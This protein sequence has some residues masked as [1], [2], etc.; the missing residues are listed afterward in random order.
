M[1]DECVWLSL[2]RQRRE[3]GEAQLLDGFGGGRR[4]WRLAMPRR[5][6]PQPRWVDAGASG[7]CTTTRTRSGLA[8]TTTNC[9]QTPAHGGTRRLLRGVHGRAWT[10]VY[11]DACADRQGLGRFPMQ[12]DDG[13]RRRARRPDRPAVWS[14]RPMRIVA[15][16]DSAL[17]TA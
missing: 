10:C 8:G 4:G 2:S 14:D 1:F 3:V 11:A 16:R 9:G 12:G 6:A 17:T 13:G 5:R 7:C 15:C